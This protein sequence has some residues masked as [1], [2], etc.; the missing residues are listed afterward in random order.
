MPCRSE[1]TWTQSWMLPGWAWILPC[2]LN[3]GKER[4]ANGRLKPQYNKNKQ[5]I[6][7]PHTSRQETNQLSPRSPHGTFFL[8]HFDWLKI[9]RGNKKNLRKWAGL[10]LTG[11]SRSEW[12][13]VSCKRFTSS[14]DLVYF[15]VWG[16]LGTRLARPWGGHRDDVRGHRQRF[17]SWSRHRRCRATGLIV[18]L[19]R[20]DV[21][22][23]CMSD[24]K[25]KIQTVHQKVFWHTSG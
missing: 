18:Q 24:V 17:I 8:S 13:C 7:H 2:V 25:V 12:G 6:S 22:K 16:P 3:A 1:E 21:F 10:W 20:L 9:T 19:D 15:M 23:N 11:K 4:K 5:A 14:R